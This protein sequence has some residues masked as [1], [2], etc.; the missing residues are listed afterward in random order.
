MLPVLAAILRRRMHPVG[1]SWRMDETY[2]KLAGQWKGSVALPVDKRV[3]GR[4]GCQF[5]KR[6]GF[7]L[8]IP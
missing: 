8:T 3:L 4:K 7:V 1:L 2:I 6:D 5:F